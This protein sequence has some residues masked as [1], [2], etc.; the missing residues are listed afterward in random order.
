MSVL[1]KALQKAGITMVADSLPK[2]QRT[3]KD[4]RRLIQAVRAAESSVQDQLSR[5]ERDLNEALQK[6]LEQQ[7]RIREL[8]AKLLQYSL[9]RKMGEIMNLTVADKT[10]L[11]ESVNL[12]C[13][14]ALA[15][16]NGR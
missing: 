2:E 9:T 16:A 6:N 12:D 8:E 7:E 13:I 11:I 15:A 4:F 14:P 10:M 5:S 3:V 1:Q